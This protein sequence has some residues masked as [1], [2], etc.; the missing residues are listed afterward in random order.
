MEQESLCEINQAQRNKIACS[1]SYV[2]SKK[3]DFIEDESIIVVTRGL[4]NRS[5]G[6]MEIN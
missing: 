2:E 6:S 5:K 4:G 1:H 3:V